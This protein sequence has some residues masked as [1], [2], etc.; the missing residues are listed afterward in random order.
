MKVKRYVKPPTIGIH[1]ARFGCR[2]V[3]RRPVIPCVIA[4]VTAL[5]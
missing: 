4:M 3:G 1:N 2:F 5:I